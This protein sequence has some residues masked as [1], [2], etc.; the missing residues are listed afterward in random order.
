[1][2]AQDHDFLAIL[3]VWSRVPRLGTLKITIHGVD[4]EADG[5]N[6]PRALSQDRSPMQRLKING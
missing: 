2:S 4:L 6:S 5:T 1:V 3:S